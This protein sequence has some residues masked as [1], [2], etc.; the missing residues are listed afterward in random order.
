MTSAGSGLES[1]KGSLGHVAKHKVG[2]SGG[3]WRPASERREGKPK[4]SERGGVAQG[5][6]GSWVGRA[7]GVMEGGV[8]GA[9]VLVY[10]GGAR[11]GCMGSGDSGIKARR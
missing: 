1:G 10:P 3:E 7:G 8:V 11:E 5:S 6:C 2:V 4:N 9:V